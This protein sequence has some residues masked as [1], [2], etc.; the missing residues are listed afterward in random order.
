VVTNEKSWLDPRGTPV[1]RIAVDLS[2]PA[3]ERW[4]SLAP[5]AEAARQLLDCYLRDLGA[6]RDLAPLIDSYAQAFVS[7][8]HREELSSIARMIG[9]PEPQVLLGNLY[10]EAFRQLVGCTA[11]ACDTPEGPI[12]ARN[13]DWWTEDQLLARLSCL[14]DVHGA[15]TGPYQ[16]VSWPGFIGAL[17]GLAPGPFAVTLNAVISSERPSLAP[18]VVLLIRRALETCRTFGEAVDLLE[19]SPIAADCLL[20]VTGTRAGEMVVI[21]RTSTRAAVRG[22]EHGFVAVTNDYRRLDAAGDAAMGGR[23]HETACGRFDRAAELLGRTLPRDPPACLRIL[24]DP[25]VRMA[26]T[27]QQMVMRPRTGELV[28]QIPV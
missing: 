20:L 13:L 8:E 25:A 4:V 22:P 3:G 6:P 5:H 14:V 16:V 9:R 26:I 27:V 19:R 10:Y 15:P 2:R 23:L 17:S 1:V 18:P 7:S 12:H 24:G 21:E 28:V 11:F